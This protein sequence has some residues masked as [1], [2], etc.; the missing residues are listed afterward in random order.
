MHLI[1]GEKYIKF[2]RIYASVSE[3]Y[4]EIQFTKVHFGKP[5]IC[6]S[7]VVILRRKVKGM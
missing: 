4:S 3:D 2:G 1:L 7:R 6:L 5:I